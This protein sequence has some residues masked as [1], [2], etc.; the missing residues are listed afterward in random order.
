MTVTLSNKGQVVIPARM[1]R[2]LGMKPHSRVEFEQRPDGILIRPVGGELPEY[3]PELSPG[4]IRRTKE[5]IR[6]GNTFGHTFGDPE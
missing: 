1:R 3:I 2:A 4:Q 6:L 5:E